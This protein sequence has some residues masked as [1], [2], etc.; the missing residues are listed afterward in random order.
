MNDVL[1]PA[2]PQ[3]AHIADLWWLTFWVCAVVL[4]AVLA[5]LAWALWRAPRADASTAP[6]ANPGSAREKKTARHV[7]A[8]VALASILLIGLLVAS[9]AT[10]RALAHLPMGDALHVRV[11]AHQWWWDVTYDDPQPT[12]IFK[13]ANE[14]HIPVGRPIL[15][16]LDSDDVIHSF[17]VPN[18]HGKKDLIPGRTATIQFRADKAGE[19]HGQCAEFCGMQ[20]AFMAF[21]VVAVPP[22][23]FEAWA[24]AQRRP[25]QEPQDAA[26]QRGRELFLSGSCMLCH[27]IQGTSANAHK[28]PDLTHVASRARIAAGRLANTPQDLAAWIADPQKLKPGVNMPAHLLPG[29]DLN[30]LVAY[31]R[32]LK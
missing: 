8:A 21:D 31:M 10:D 19:Y 30:A 16:T 23:Q 7:I 2:G 4:V 3:A 9:V 18:L 11:T 24:E 26:A 28:A 12:R 5:A 20:H 1:N 27:A 25:A 32:T 22:E 15:V 6:D 13:T 17:W 29:E 14:L